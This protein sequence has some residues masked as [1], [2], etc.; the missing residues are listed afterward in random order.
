MG[1]CRHQGLGVND[2]EI[3]LWDQAVALYVGSVARDTG[4]SGYML[5][6]LANDYCYRFG[7]CFK[8]HTAAINHKIMKTFNS[9]QKNLKD[10]KCASVSK[11]AND[12]KS[13]MLVPL[14]QAALRV[15]YALDVEN[16]HN[17]STEGEAAAYAAALLP[18]MHDCGRGN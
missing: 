5:Y 13:L 10:G 8:G 1:D 12:I 14:I 18:L 3:Y 11:D 2:G 6:T 17:E 4:K 15:M 9:G 7:R 16:I